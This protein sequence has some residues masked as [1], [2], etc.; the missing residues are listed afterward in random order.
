ML[1]ELRLLVLVHALLGHGHVLD[2][3]VVVVMIMLVVELMMCYI[4]RV[5][6]TTKNRLVKYTLSTE[7]RF[8]IVH[9]NKTTYFYVEQ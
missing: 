6:D 3:V 9:L 8:N 2:I 5:A 1:V 7:K 4:L